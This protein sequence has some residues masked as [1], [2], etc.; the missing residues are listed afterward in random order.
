[1]KEYFIVMGQIGIALIIAIVIVIFT[2]NTIDNYLAPKNASGERIE[3]GLTVYEDPLTGC[4]YVSPKHKDGLFP[5]FDHHGHH[6]C[7]Q[8]EQ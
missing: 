2:I 7:N 8:M 5:R 3:R 4:Q 6:I 1:M